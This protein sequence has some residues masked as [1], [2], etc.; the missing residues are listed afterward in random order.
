MRKKYRRDIQRLKQQQK[1][2]AET[3]NLRQLVWESY[4]E[5]LFQARDEE[6]YQ[7][8]FLYD[9]NSTLTDFVDTFKITRPIPLVEDSYV[10][11]VC[12]FFVAAF[13][14]DVLLPL[15]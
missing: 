7:Q 6:E 1:E 11:K 8:Q 3:K 15:R 14:Y 13:F 10:W 2:D 12:V 4:H 9:P 5:L